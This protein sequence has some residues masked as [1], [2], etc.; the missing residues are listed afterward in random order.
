M[1]RTLKETIEIAIAV[2][3][4]SLSRAAA[5]CAVVDKKDDYDEVIRLLFEDFSD[6]TPPRA[7]FSPL[8]LFERLIPELTLDQIMV[9]V[10]YDISVPK[11]EDG[12]QLDG[13]FDLIE[14]WT[15]EHLDVMTR[16]ERQL[17]FEQIM[18]AH[19]NKRTLRQ[20]VHCMIDLLAPTKFSTHP[21]WGLIKLAE[22]AARQ[23]DGS[24]GYEDAYQHVFNGIRSLFYQQGIAAEDW[25]MSE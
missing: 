14:H 15:I 25:E 20:G 10:G 2:H 22:D 12:A 8:K 18:T 4:D 11:T 16:A 24:P 19:Y 3:V 6:P 9:M 21:L 23:N 17:F 7:T 5:I 13:I 1:E